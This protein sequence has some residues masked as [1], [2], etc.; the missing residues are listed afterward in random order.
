MKTW[1]KNLLAY[2]IVAASVFGWSK[3]RE[4]YIGFERETQKIINNDPNSQRIFNLEEELYT[5]LDAKKQASYSLIR[6]V[7]LTQQT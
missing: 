7:A 1:K 6:V 4:Q 5:H 2:T 3:C